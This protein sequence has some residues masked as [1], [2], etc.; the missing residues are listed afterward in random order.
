MDNL[1]T[2][3]DYIMSRHAESLWITVDGVS[4]RIQRTEDGARVQLFVAG[5]ETGEPLDEARAFVRKV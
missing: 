1:L 4:V 3:T 2:D 5:E